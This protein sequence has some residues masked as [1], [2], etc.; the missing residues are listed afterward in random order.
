MTF[1]VLAYDRY[2]KIHMYHVYIPP[3]A[4]STLNVRDT[5]M[6]F[7]AGILE[8]HFQYVRVYPLRLAPSGVFSK[9]AVF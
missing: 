8:E 2:E 5:F 4:P 9:V 1:V 3:P 7:A 6:V